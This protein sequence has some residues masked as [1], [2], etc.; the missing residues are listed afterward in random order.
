MKMSSARCARYIFFHPLFPSRKAEKVFFGISGDYL[1]LKDVG[2]RF[3]I[4]LSNIM[5][6]TTRSIRLQLAP[7]AARMGANS[8]IC[9][10]KGSS[11]RRLA[12]S[13]CYDKIVVYKYSFITV[14]SA[15]KDYLPILITTAFLHDI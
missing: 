6:N 7:Y 12:C 10:E 2:D 14:I 5:R 4:F 3:K 9:D 11:V 15:E 1:S 8:Y 13:F